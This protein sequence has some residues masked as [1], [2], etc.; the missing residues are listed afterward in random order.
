MYGRG[1]SSDGGWFEGR[2]VGCDDGRVCWDC[3]GGIAEAGRGGAGGGGITFRDGRA[4]ESALDGGGGGTGGGAGAGGA[5]AFVA[6][7]LPFA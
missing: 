3:G 6:A 2:P 4:M 5:P 7:P 1:G